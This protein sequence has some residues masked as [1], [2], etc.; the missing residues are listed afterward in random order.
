MAAVT[1]V[2]T[3]IARRD[4]WTTLTIPPEDQARPRG[5]MARAAY[6]PAASIF[7]N[8]TAF[9]IAAKDAADET[10][11]AITMTLPP[12]YYYRIAFIEIGLLAPAIIDLED[13]E[14]AA[15]VEIIED[16][17]IVGAFALYNQVE[18]ATGGAEP[19]FKGQPDAV[20]NDFVTFYGPRPA[21]LQTE[22]IDARFGTSTIVIALLD[23]SADATAV[24]SGFVRCRVWQ[25]TVDQGLM[26]AV[27]TP[28][29]VV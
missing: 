10:E 5:V 23:S 20:T 15:R 17:S 11:I 21:L 22:L 3:P 28:T 18:Y 25:Y 16:S 2:V 24:M 19:G 6:M 12:N 1:I 8:T 29:L 9:T 14:K 13:F 4:P 27:H 7:F 26:S